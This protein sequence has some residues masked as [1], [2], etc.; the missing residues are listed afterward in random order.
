MPKPETFDVETGWAVCQGPHGQLT[1][2]PV[3]SGTRHN[4]VIPMSCPPGYRP[5][6]A[7]HI[8]PPGYPNPSAQ[9]IAEAQRLSL[10]FVCAT[11][12]DGKRVCVNT[13]R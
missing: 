13:K 5:I 12:P 8:H 7:D 2:G 9:D 3:A 6:G 4:V 11:S 10:E 1:S